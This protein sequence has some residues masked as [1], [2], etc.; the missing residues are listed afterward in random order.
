MVCKPWQNSLVA[1][2]LIPT[3]REFGYAQ[4][5]ARGH[6]NLLKDIQDEVNDEGHGLIKRVDEPRRSR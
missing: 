5:R 3:L 1:K 2:W 4:I 6:S